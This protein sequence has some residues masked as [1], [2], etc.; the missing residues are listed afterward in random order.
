MYKQLLLHLLRAS[1]FFDDHSRY[2]EQNFLQEEHRTPNPTSLNLNSRASISL[3][4]TVTFCVFFTKAYAD[5]CDTLPRLHQNDGCPGAG[6]KGFQGAMEQLQILIYIPKRSPF[7]YRR[8]LRPHHKGVRPPLPGTLRPGCRQL[9]RS[10]AVRHM[11][12]MSC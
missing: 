9:R 7:H 5:F 1:S 11:L 12:S 8:L 2:I 4:F 6:S 3:I 10:Y